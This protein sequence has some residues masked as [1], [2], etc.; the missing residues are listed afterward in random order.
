LK[1]YQHFDPAK[2]QDFAT[3]SIPPTPITSLEKPLG[4]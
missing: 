3:F 2:P 4:N 1:E